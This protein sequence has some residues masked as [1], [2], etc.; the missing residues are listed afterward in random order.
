MT[1][2]PRNVVGIYRVATGKPWHGYL[3]FDLGS[4]PRWLAF[5][6]SNL[7]QCH[8]NHSL[9]F[10]VAAIYYAFFWDAAFARAGTLASDW[11]LH[12]VAYNLAA[13]LATF[14]FW[15][16]MTY[17]LSTTSAALAPYK[18]DKT[19]QYAAGTT[20]LH[21]EV[22]LTTMGLLMSSAYQVAM[23]HLWASGRVPYIASFAANPALVVGQVLL[24]TYW[25][26]LHFYWCVRGGGSLWWWTAHLLSCLPSHTHL[27]PPP[28]MPCRVHRAM[29]PWWDRKN[30]LAD[31]DVGAFLY[32]W[33]HS[34]H[35]QSYNPGVR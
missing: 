18:Y 17:G 28:P 8:L 10:T 4:W 3:L 12:V 9:D 22:A 14:G 27:P 35:H 1:Y 16:L 24:V 20:N 19:D 15:H 29:H 6:W 5:L 31:G 26:E 32:R 30:G 7:V 33:A 34:L 25:R 13:G 21:R 23:M 11:V 2:T